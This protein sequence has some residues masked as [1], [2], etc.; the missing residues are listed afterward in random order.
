MA[1][2]LVGFAYATM[3]TK[4]TTKTGTYTG[5]TAH[6]NADFYGGYL[7]NP[8]FHNWAWV[9]QQLPSGTKLCM[10]YRWKVNGTVTVDHKT[11]YD[12]AGTGSLDADYPYTGTVTLSTSQSRA[13]YSDGT[14]TWDTEWAIAS[15]PFG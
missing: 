13:G 9:R 8:Y 4:E 1:I 12:D 5:T 3:Q 6:V 10:E 15:I 2:L 7:H 11:I 14:V